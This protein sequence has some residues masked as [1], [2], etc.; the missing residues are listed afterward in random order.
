MNVH[1][2]PSAIRLRSRSFSSNVQRILGITQSFPRLQPELDKAA[3]MIESVQPGAIYKKRLN[4]LIIE[5]S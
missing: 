3:R 1:D 4:A 5:G 2:L